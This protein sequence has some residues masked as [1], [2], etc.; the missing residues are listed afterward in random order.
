MKADDLVTKSAFA[1]IAGVTAG[2]VSQWIADGKI[3]GDALV[4]HGYRARI[5]VTAA[6]A[7]LRRTLDPT[8]AQVN[9]NGAAGDITDDIR[10]RPTSVVVSHQLSER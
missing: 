3:T 9:G 10:R 7:Q 4:G 8:R 1:S 2:R 5:K 6:L